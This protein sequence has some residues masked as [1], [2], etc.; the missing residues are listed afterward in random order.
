MTI[1]PAPFRVVLRC[2]DGSESYGY[3]DSLRLA[4]WMLARMKATSTAALRIERRAIT[5]P[6]VVSWVAV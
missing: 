5:G 1:A 4:R 3:A 2:L 6:G